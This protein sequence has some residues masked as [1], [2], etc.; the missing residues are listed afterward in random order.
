MINLKRLAAISFAAIMTLSLTACGGT[1]NNT[2]SENNTSDTKSDATVDDGSTTEELEEGLT[3]QTYD[4]GVFLMSKANV[5]RLGRTVMI[6]DT[7]WFSYSASGVEFNFTGS[8]LT[9][10]LRS[11]SKYM[12]EANQVRFAIYVDGERVVDEMM[13]EAFKNVEVLNLSA[14]ETHVIKFVKLS[15]SSSSTIGIQHVTCDESAAISPTADKDLKI[16]FIGDSITCGYGVDG[17]LGDKFSTT[18]EDATKAYAYLTAEEL[19]ADYSL[20]SF[21]GYGIISGYTNGDKVE[22]QQLPKYYDY[23][24]N[25]YGTFALGKKTSETEWD[26]TQYTPDVVVINLG[27]NDASYTKG[28]SSK[29]EEYIE[30]YYDFIGTIR[31]KYPDAAI[32]CTLGLMGQDLYPQIEEAVDRYTADN[33]DE[34]VYAFCL[35]VQDSANGY[36]VDYHPTLASHQH[37]ADQLSEA[38]TAILSGNYN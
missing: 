36:A 21:S 22:S 27:T 3:G 6:D 20:V 33:S 10:D 35:D 23:I 8:S 15:E 14:S 9:F 29:C 5:K 25:S 18:N 37:A 26:F 38:I 34:N 31:L 28:D 13:D 4:P 1:S 19:D 11:D 17:T 32:V 30:A 16:E 12:E 2:S 7:L 24:G